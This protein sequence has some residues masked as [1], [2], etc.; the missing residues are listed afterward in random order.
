M[1]PYQQTY[2]VFTIICAFLIFWNIFIAL[3]L[4]IGGAVSHAPQ[5]MWDALLIWLIVSVIGLI[6]TALTIKGVPIL[7]DFKTKLVVMIFMICVSF[8]PTLPSLFQK[9]IYGYVNSWEISH[10]QQVGLTDTTNPWPILKC[11]NGDT[12]EKPTDPNDNRRLWDGGVQSTYYPYN[13]FY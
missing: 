12:V 13:F 4:A 10:C 11:D 7:K 2:R 3:G 5:M 9:E 1:Q 8:I 6:L